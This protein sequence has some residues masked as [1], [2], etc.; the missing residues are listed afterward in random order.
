VTF[1]ELGDGELKEGSGF[2]IIVDVVPPSIGSACRN[3]EASTMLKIGRDC[4]GVVEVDQLPNCESEGSKVA[5]AGGRDPHS[6]WIDC[7]LL[8]TYKLGEVPLL[9]C[10]ALT[11]ASSIEF[12]GFS[13][14]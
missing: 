5:I 11:L 6:K 2:P 8:A 3:V 13:S 4:L 10:V 12:T 1:A 7:N 14:S 9:K